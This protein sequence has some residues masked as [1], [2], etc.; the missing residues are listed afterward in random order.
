MKRNVK[1][2]SWVLVVSTITWFLIGCGAGTA[3]PS[4]SPTPGAEEG[5]REWIDAIVNQDGNRMLKHT[6]KAQR[7]NVKEAGMWISAF[8]VLGQLLTNR[9]VQIDGDISDLKFETISQS[10][11]QAE[12]RVYGELRVAVLANAEAYDVDEHWQMVYENETWRWCGSD[13]ASLAGLP[14]IQPTPTPVPQSVVTPASAK[15]PTPI[16]TST[17]TSPVIQ[18]VGGREFVA[19]VATFAEQYRCDP[20]TGTWS[21]NFNWE[22]GYFVNGKKEKQAWIDLASDNRPQSSDEVPDDWFDPSDSVTPDN[23]VRRGYITRIGDYGFYGWPGITPNQAYRWRVAHLIDGEWYYSNVATFTTGAC[24][25]DPNWTPSPTATSDLQVTAEAER[26]QQVLDNAPP[27]G[28]LPG[29]IVFAGND[30]FIYKA[31]GDGSEKTRYV[32]PEVVLEGHPISLSPNGAEMLLVDSD[33]ELYLITLA[34]NIDGLETIRLTFNEAIDAYPSWSADGKQIVFNRTDPGA[35]IFL[36]S[37]D[38]SGETNITESLDA[39]EWMPSISPDGKQVAFVLANSSSASQICVLNIDGVDRKCLTQFDNADRWPMWSPD[40][41]KIAFLRPSYKPRGGARYLVYAV[42]VM[43]ADGS[44]LTQLTDYLLESEWFDVERLLFWSPD[45][46]QIA[47]PV[48]GPNTVGTYI[49]DVD[50]GG[51]SRFGE[52]VV[53]GWLPE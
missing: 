4:P 26:M 8:A 37:A 15:P 28:P 48:F 51:L 10:G 16:I 46:Q 27:A 1:H 19:P 13:T 17:P 2:I 20:K 3:E 6:C 43:N 44:E 41:N 39:M 5:A 35:D 30:G 42:F 32:V 22:P 31:K 50:G 53:L 47:F 21:I 18:Q 33:S 34:E 24:A 36:M 45:G 11:D 25:P 7:E 49:V 23:F 29:Q 14:V 40:G 52:G 38:G 9:S 12:V